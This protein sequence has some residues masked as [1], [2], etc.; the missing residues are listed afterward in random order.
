MLFDA[1]SVPIGFPQSC[2]ASFG[3][4]PARNANNSLAYGIYVD[5]DQ[6]SREKEAHQLAGQVLGEQLDQLAIRV[7]HSQLFVRWG[8]GFFEEEP[9][10]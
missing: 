1:K 2:P 6:P 4:V 9:R 8:I 7:L 5:L 10:E 3:A